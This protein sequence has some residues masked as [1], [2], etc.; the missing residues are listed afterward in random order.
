MDYGVTVNLEVAY[1]Y[2]FLFQRTSVMV[3]YKVWFSTSN[4]SEE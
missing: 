1:F 4:L 3:D 2:A